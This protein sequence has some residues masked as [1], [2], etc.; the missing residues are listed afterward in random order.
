MC[1]LVQSRGKQAD[2]SHETTSAYSSPLW[3]QTRGRVILG[4]YGDL[5]QHSVSYIELTSA[6]SSQMKLVSLLTKL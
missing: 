1:S 6:E 3:S 4:G 5:A 2:V